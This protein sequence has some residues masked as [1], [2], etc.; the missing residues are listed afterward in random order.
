M[1]GHGGRIERLWS[2]ARAVE[3]LPLDAPVGTVRRMEQVGA[4]ARA[5]EE[6]MYQLSLDHL[7]GGWRGP[8]SSLVRPTPRS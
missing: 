2:A 7:L 4:R 1:D 6:F 8:S 5:H 3:N